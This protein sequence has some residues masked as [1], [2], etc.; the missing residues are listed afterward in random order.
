MFKI[1]TLL[2]LF[3]IGFTGCG[4]SAHAEWSKPIQKK[5]L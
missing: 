4:P 2:A 5:S 3:I 1:V